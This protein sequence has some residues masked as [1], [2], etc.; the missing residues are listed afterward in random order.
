MCKII[1]L[2]ARLMQK[3]QEQKADLPDYTDKASIADW[4][5]DFVAQAAAEGLM[6]GMDD[7]RFMPKASATRAQAATV[8]YRL[9]RSE[10]LQQNTQTA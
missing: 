10:G 3:L 4:A 5:S 7:G 8:F 2:T 9:L 1:V 6:Q